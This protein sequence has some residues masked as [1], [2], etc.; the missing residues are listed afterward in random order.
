M[1]TRNV[2]QVHEIANNSENQHSDDGVEGRTAAAHQAGAANHNGSD[3]IELHAN[4][5]HGRTNAGA[6]GFYDT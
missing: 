3:H 2:L 5:D 6:S 4:T 1:V